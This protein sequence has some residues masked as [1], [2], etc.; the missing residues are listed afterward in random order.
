MILAFAG[1]VGGARLANGLARILPAGGLTVAVNTG[2]DFEHLGLHISPDPDTVL[3]TLAGLNDPERGW[4]L[5]G[6][7]FACMAAVKRLGGEHWFALGDR[8]L[9]THLERTRRL[10]TGETLS[11]IIADFAA[12]FGINQAIVPVTDDRLRTLVHTADGELTF[13]DYFVRRRCEPAVTA[14][15]FEGAAQASP[16]PGLAALMQSPDLQG[17]IICPSNPFLSIDPILAVPGIRT[18][19]T[20]RRVPCIAVSPLIGGRAVKGPIAKMLAELSLD[21]TPRAIAEHYLG[22]IDGLIIDRA[23]TLQAFGECHITDTLMRDVPG[24]ERLARDS[25]NYLEQLRSTALK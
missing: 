23:D 12:R 2:D 20:H 25:L 5:A 9:A 15:V 7:T 3:Y 13:Q 4:G 19:L 17:I 8:D 21:A 14:L 11:R 10:A 16:S 22:L 18:W 6:E 24:Q 1:G